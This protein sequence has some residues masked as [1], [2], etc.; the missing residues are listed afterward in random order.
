MILI[1]DLTDFPGSLWPGI[2]DIIGPD[3]RVILVGNKVDLLPQDSYHHLQNVKS[4][5]LKNFVKKCRLSGLKHKP[6]VLDSVLVSA[7]TGFN[8][9]WLITLIFKNWRDKHFH[10]GGHVYL[11]GTTNVGKSSIF[12]KLLDSDLCDV[13]AMHRI[14][15]ATTSPIPGTTLNLLKFPIMRPEPAELSERFT[16]L[17]KDAEVIKANERER[18]A[19]LRKFKSQRYFNGF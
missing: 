12:N 15:K 8:L 16:R 2:L 10:L 9:E 6:V 1:V 17:K 7:R 14:D 11:I 3:K 18:I 19:N 4:S 13:R 5:M